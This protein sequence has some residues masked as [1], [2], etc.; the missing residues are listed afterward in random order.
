M[1]YKLLL[2]EDYGYFKTETYK[3]RKRVNILIREGILAKTY[4]NG[5]NGQELIYMVGKKYYVVVALLEKKFRHFYTYN[6]KKGTGYI[7]LTNCFEYVQNRWEH[8]EKIKI[9]CVDVIKCI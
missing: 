8:I 5:L 4:L 3:L 2:G 6:L 9:A 1:T 7:F